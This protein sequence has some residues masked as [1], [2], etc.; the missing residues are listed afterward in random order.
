[1]SRRGSTAATSPSAT[2]GPLPSQAS[3]GPP[4]RFTTSWLCVSWCSRMTGSTTTRTA[5]TRRHGT[6]RSADGSAWSPALEHQISEADRRLFRLKV[7]GALVVPLEARVLIV[8]VVRVFVG[9]DHL[10]DVVL[11]A[12]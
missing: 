5:P 12:L 8:F 6:R 1:M 4:E 7:L 9:G 2:P 3:P 10:E 11:N